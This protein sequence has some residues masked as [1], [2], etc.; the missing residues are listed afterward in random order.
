MQ[1]IEKTLVDNIEFYTQEDIQGTTVVKKCTV[2]KF[3]VFIGK[4]KNVEKSTNTVN[5]VFEKG[6]NCK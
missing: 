3:V 5:E 1:T 4:S 6:H 2:C